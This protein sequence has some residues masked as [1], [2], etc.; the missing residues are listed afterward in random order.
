MNANLRTYLAAAIALPLTACAHAAM[1]G[2]MGLGIGMMG[3]HR[4]ATA[5]ESEARAM[6]AHL[7]RVDTIGA[8]QMAAIIP[9]HVRRLEALLDGCESRPS[10]ASPSADTVRGMARGL[11]EDLSRLRQA[12][13]SELGVFMPEHNA[14]VWAFLS[15]QHRGREDHSHTRGEIGGLE[16]LTPLCRV[17]QLMAAAGLQGTRETR[18]FAVPLGT[19]SLYRGR[20][21]AEEVGS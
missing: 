11:R 15:L 8:E 9:V 5:C 2:G 10:D 13:P 21:A 3:H 4:G 18:R 17:P 14:R 7:Q 1:M 19:V 16:P 20:K 6:E 12:S